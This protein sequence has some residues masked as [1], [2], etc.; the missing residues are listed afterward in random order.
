MTATRSTQEIARAEISAISDWLVVVA[1]HGK[2]TLVS[3]LELYYS[4][5]EAKVQP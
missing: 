2:T 1:T 4:K 5:D 3:P